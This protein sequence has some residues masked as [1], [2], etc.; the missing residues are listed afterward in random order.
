MVPTFHIPMNTTQAD[1]YVTGGTLGQNVPSYVPRQAD[2]ELYEGLRQGE[3]C[4]VLTSR[5]MG[6]SSLMVRAAAR[7]RSDG[8]AVAVLDLTGIGVNVTA[9]Q[10]YDGLLTRVGEQ[11]DLEDELEDFWLAHERT[12]PLNRWMQAIEQVALAR[13]EAQLVI[14][15]DEIDA[16]R[17]L[18][19]SADEFFAGIREC[20]N[21]RAENPEMCRLTFCL[22]GVA[23]PSDLI[24]DPHMT[25]FNIG[26]RIQLDDF[27]G[28]EAE[29]LSGGFG[30]EP[31]AAGKLLD[32]VL[33]WTGGHP[34][35]TQRL[36]K[37]AAGDANVK[38]P[39]DVDRVC[40]EGF[41]THPACERDDNLSFVRQRLLHS[42][43]DLAGLL[44][45]YDKV[46]RHK[47]VE[48]DDT[49]PLIATL[50][51]AGIVRAAG[52]H[53]EVRN[54]IYAK[55]FD[56][57][58]VQ[59]NMPDAELRRQRAAF[60]RG[61]LRASAV[62]CV[63]ILM[64]TA[65][66]LFAFQ[67]WRRADAA[68]SA[69]RRERQ[70]A[71]AQ[72]RLAVAAQRKAEAAQRK[73]EATQD[74]LRH[75]LLVAKQ[76]RET[77]LAETDK[78][79]QAKRDADAA[80]R[81]TEL[82]KQRAD[83]EKLKAMAA[84]EKTQEAL[85]QAKAAT[86]IAIEKEGLAKEN[87]RLAKEEAAR[88]ERTGLMFKELLPWL[89]DH[90]AEGVQHYAQS[91][92]DKGETHEAI[93]TSLEF[94]DLALGDQLGFQAHELLGLDPDEVAM[95]D[96]DDEPADSRVYVK[97]LTLLK[98]V[99]KPA[100]E[101]GEQELREKA[102]PADKPLVAEL[103]ATRAR[104]IQKLND[105]QRPADMTLAD[106]V[107]AYDRA[108]Q[109]DTE[110]F[111]YY[112]GRAGARFRSA[113]RDLVQIREDLQQAL[114]C[115]PDPPQPPSTAETVT[116]SQ[117]EVAAL[118][119]ALGNI[120]ERIAHQDPGDDAAG[121][122]EDAALAHDRAHKLNPG[123][124]AYP[125]AVART[126]RKRSRH[127]PA[128]GEKQKQLQKALELLDEAATIDE[129]LP[130]ISNERGEVYLALNDVVKARQAFAQ[131]AEASRDTELQKNQ[132]RYL[133][134]LANAHLRE[135]M[136]ES[137]LRHALQAAGEAIAL[138]PGQAPEGHYFRGRALWQLK[139]NSEAMQEFDRVLRFKP[140]HIGALLA[141]SQIVFDSRSPELTKDHLRRARADVDRA[142]ELATETPATRQDQAIAYYISS[143]GW[144][145]DYRLVSSSERSLLKC[146]EDLVN[147]ARAAPGYA[148]GGDQI[149]LYAANV[150]AEKSGWEDAEN[151]KEFEALRQEFQRLM[152]SD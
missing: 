112:A 15:V 70:S 63:V 96:L 38:T 11:L 92:V 17:S 56:R 128:A 117:R 62:A 145:R 2:Q 81:V 146:L 115:Y 137:A 59:A 57:E 26:R 80:K 23:T 68:A 66:V 32:R 90:A 67:Q 143:V 104:L 51:L 43:V 48:A 6:K 20:Y 39:A 85:E 50:R 93:N 107:A 40:R 131:A 79:L 133:C 27:R 42:D 12:S 16:V 31:V 87:A 9:E 83:D 53:L 60:R 148:P 123:E 45:Q 134:N 78:A 109:L 5:Q 77:A 97:P 28:D 99:L 49:K 86:Q 111:S 101:L 84:N 47:R 130:E 122:Y 129:E 25:P 95:L 102:N 58:W 65:S 91:L 24:Q 35:L 89:A 52:P 103:H 46:L 1:F 142:V 151:R 75:Q 132:Y 33:Y 55:V 110:K 13:T 139:R 94:C 7:L 82:E 14:F 116:E 3:F 106:A 69:E 72:E 136:S 19:F 30:D 147:S 64:L 120:V 118:H 22:L 113:D 124:A 138:Q 41:I 73:V 44:E 4:Y 8:A 144:L 149:F 119:H 71:E 105:N 37:S 61:L 150:H 140:E 10:W 21:R 152:K 36:C 141:R 125:L 126:L 114:A 34:Y 18:N 100:I 29:I 135:P 127:C 88:A 74:A 54:G 121:L 98:A 108:I 76:A